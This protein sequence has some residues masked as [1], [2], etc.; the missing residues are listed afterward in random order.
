MIDQN[1]CYSIQFQ[2]WDGSWLL[3]GP[4]GANGRLLFGTARDAVS[5][6]RWDAKD[7]GG[8]IEV[9]DPHGQLFKVIEIAPDR[10]GDESMVLPSV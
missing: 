2:P 10:S 8:I 1:V 6:A 5:H 4:V 3:A 7:N 9:Q